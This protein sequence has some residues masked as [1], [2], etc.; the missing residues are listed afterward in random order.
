MPV[1]MHPTFPRLWDRRL[2]RAADEGRISATQLKNLRAFLRTP[3]GQKEL[4]KCQTTVN[5][6]ARANGVAA[7][8]WQGILQW[9]RD[10]WEQIVQIILSL[11]MF[12]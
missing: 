3:K 10:H 12:I 6:L 4:A 11:L 5:K 7:I 2:K 1:T 9:I 8:D